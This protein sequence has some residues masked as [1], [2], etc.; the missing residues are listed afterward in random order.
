MREQIRQLTEQ[1]FSQRAI[2]ETL[3]LSRGTVY[4]CQRELNL[5]LDRHGPRAPEL[6]K[7]QAAR[8]LTLLRGGL[9]IHRVCKRLKVREWAVRKSAKQNN[10][11]RISQW[12]ALAP[13]EQ[14]KILEEIR[15]RRNHGLD[16]ASKYGVSYKL[17]LRLAH[18]ELGCLR[19]CSGAAQPP[20]SSN[21]PA[22][23]FQ[24]ND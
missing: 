7:R 9:S 4:R 14:R 10:I 16:L 8:V 1:G 3:K 17:I 11:P 13:S 22:R 5:C 12:D 24:A 20:L 18:R 21:F 19:F 6:S 23:N 2:C 15:E